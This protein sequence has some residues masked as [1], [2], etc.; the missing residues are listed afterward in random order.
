MT[1]NKSSRADIEALVRLLLYAESEAERLGLAQTAKLARIPARAG[2]REAREKFGIG[3]G[4]E[5]EPDSV[6]PT[7]H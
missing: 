5:T 4:L 3:V 2:I 1:F 6:K 7:C